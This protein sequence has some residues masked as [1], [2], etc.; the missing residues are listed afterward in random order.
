M[1]AKLSVV[2]EKGNQ[3]NY[4]IVTTITPEQYNAFKEQALLE[5][6][7]TY[8][9]DGYRPGKVPLDM[10]RKEVNEI[11]LE[12]DAMNDIINSSLDI[13]LQEHKDIKFIG[14]PYN[15]DKKVEWDNTVFTYNLDVYPEVTVLND[16]WKSIRVEAVDGQVT[17]E[18]LDEAIKSLRQQYA[19]YVDTSAVSHHSV[20]RLKVI[21]MNADSEE[22][23]TKTIFVEHADKHDGGFHNLEGKVVGDVIQLPYNDSVPAKLKY[24]KEDQIPTTIT[25]E[26]LKTQTQE[27]PEF[28]DEKIQ[29]LFG[30][31]G[32]TSLEIL[33]GKI[34][35]VMKEQKY[36]NTLI[37]NVDSYVASISPSFEV[38][39]PK[40]MIE[41]EYENRYKHMTE[42]FGGKEKFEAAYLQLP[43]GKTELEK[44]QTELRDISKASLAK[45]FVLQKVCELLEIKD[46][47]RDK[48]LDVE[49]KLYDHFNKA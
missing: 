47:A 26:V 18:E 36:Q 33:K 5:F 14:Q 41:S 24:G 20:D 13:L 11:Y 46:I 1:K 32:V 16:N 3:S 2:L 22:I 30:N 49:T 19:T 43:E 42:R 48:D 29:E 12:M 8:K 31:E 25:L 9:K 17:A 37:G 23:F 10:V 35:E 34:S 6:A 38:Q 28:T 27:L 45:F 39:I 40:A 15:L 21:Y 44:R 4:Q 7:K